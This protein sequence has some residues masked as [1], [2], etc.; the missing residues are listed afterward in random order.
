MATLR[1][2]RTAELR[3]SATSGFARGRDAGRAGNCRGELFPK[4]QCAN[5]RRHPAKKIA[6]P[7]LAGLREQG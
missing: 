2:E 4:W 5:C 1:L 7:S 3:Q 6:Q